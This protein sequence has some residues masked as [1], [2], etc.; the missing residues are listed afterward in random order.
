[1]DLGQVGLPA[2]TKGVLLAFSEMLA[3]SVGMHA[4]TGF[5]GC[6]LTG[7]S[8]KGIKSYVSLNVVQH[9]YLA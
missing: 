1:M 7:K 5:S 8:I 2:W 9:V 4:A 6:R 3:C